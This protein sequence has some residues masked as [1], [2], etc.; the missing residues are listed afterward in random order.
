MKVTMGQL[1]KKGEGDYTYLEKR[2]KTRYNRNGQVRNRKEKENF[3][4]E[5]GGVQ[6]YRGRVLRGGS[7]DKEEE[8]VGMGERE[9]GEV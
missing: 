2:T 6:R 7:P 9:L 8:G 1:S 4:G 3:F 5:R